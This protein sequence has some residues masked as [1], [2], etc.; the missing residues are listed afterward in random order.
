MHSSKVMKSLQVYNSLDY[1][2]RCNKG[3]HQEITSKETV[4]CN[5][6]HEAGCLAILP[7]GGIML[8]ISHYAHNMHTCTC[9]NIRNYSA[10]VQ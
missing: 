10:A 5:D 7:W 3:V 2:M 9:I 8:I 4:S 1:S 6:P